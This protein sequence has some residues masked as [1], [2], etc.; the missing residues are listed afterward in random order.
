LFGTHSAAYHFDLA[1]NLQGVAYPNTVTNFYQYD[2]LNR[3]TNLVWQAGNSPLASFIYTLGA[4]GNRTNLVE[5]V[6]GIARNYQWQYDPLYRLTNETLSS[7]PVGILFYQ[8]DTTTLYLVDTLN[9][10]G[11]V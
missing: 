10:S 6:D 7:T 8:Y 4:T 1:G 3:L 9:P 11:Y 2:S 5:S